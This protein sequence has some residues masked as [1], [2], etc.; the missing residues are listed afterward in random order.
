MSG[1]GFG[2]NGRGSGNV[3]ETARPT[4][5]TP[6]DHRPENSLGYIIRDTHLAFA[7]FLRAR[8]TPYKV[9]PGQWFF[10][11]ALWDEEGL[12]QREL[13]MRVRTTEPTTASALRV[14]ERNGLVRRIRNESDRRSINVHL[15]ERG[16]DLKQELLPI[17]LEI[18]T[19]AQEGLSPE[20][21][22]VVKRLTGR[23][24]ENVAAAT[25]RGGAD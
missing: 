11:R 10:L 4:V 22:R 13:S 14:L 9:T 24:R 23:M 16:R 6:P 8:L 18:N 12:S 7:R 3:P 2:Q 17:V 5:A 19:A 21:I 20:E 15:T 25:D 1:R